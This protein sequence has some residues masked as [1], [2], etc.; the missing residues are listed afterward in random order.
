MRHCLQSLGYAHNET[1][2]RDLF[3]PSCC[4]FMTAEHFSQHLL[5]PYRRNLL[6]DSPFLYIR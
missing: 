6:R 4:V 5:P 2:A 3:L 1:G